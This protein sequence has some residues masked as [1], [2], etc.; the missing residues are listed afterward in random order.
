MAKLHR[1][2]K[3]QLGHAVINVTGLHD[4]RGIV[5]RIKVM[6]DKESYVL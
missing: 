5:P 3:Y 2:F 4:R 1:S 6:G